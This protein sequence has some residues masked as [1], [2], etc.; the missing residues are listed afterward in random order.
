MCENSRTTRSHTQNRA[1]LTN[2]RL[3]GHQYSAVALIVCY[4]VESSAEKIIDETLKTSI[5]TCF[6][7]RISQTAPSV[8]ILGR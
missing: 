3:I 1:Y 6:F 2:R 4:V 7:A 8:L 5:L